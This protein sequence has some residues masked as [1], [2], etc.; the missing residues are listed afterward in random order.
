MK[1][2]KILQLKKKFNI[3]LQLM[4]NE[5]IPFPYEI[6]ITHSDICYRHS[7]TSLFFYF[8]YYGIKT[9]GVAKKFNGLT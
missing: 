9:H 8:Y 7:E 1:D 5:M 3:N 4:P 2:V 6:K